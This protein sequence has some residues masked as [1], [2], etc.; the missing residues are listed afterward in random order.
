MSKI[1]IFDFL[2]SCRITGRKVENQIINN[3]SKKNKKIIEIYFKHSKKNKPMFDMLQK[4]GFVYR[5]DKFTK[6]Y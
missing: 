3:F 6:K 1:E 2:M 4:L 5:N